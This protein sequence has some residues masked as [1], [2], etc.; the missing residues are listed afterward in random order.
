MTRRSLIQRSAALFGLMGLAVFLF[1]IGKGHTLLLDT[2]AITLNGQEIS[3]ADNVEVSVD[4]QEPESMGRAE[5][6]MVSVGGPTHTIQIEVIDGDGRKV[7]AKFTVPTFMDMA[8]VSI[9]AILGNAPREHWV[10]KFTPPPPEEAAAEQM[11]MQDDTPVA[12]AP[13][14][15]LKPT[16]GTAA[17]KAP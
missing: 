14:M 6:S 1:Y 4:G 5:R 15:E 17:P 7:E 2:N 12:P 9:P 10:T 11:Q 13:G 16:P 3:S 8:V